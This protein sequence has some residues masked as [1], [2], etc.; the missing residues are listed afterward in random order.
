MLTVWS[1]LQGLLAAAAAVAL[2]AL[3]VAIVVNWLEQ[4]R[5]RV[6]HGH[7]RAPARHRFMW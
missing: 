3:L 5:P 1:V 2:W 7:H 6:A 4:Q